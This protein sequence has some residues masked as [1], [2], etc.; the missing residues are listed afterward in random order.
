[1]SF[2]KSKISKGNMQNVYILQ[3]FNMDVYGRI[4]SEKTL[5]TVGL[6]LQEL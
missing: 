3:V 2:N 6:M 4:Q 1:M 5:Q